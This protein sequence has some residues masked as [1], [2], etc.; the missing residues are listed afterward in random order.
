MIIPIV[1][2]VAFYTLAERKI[3]A[4]IQRRTGPN[5]VG[6]WGILQPFADA[7]K[8]IIKEQVKPLRAGFYLFLFAPILTFFISLLALNFLCFKFSRSFFDEYLNFLFF[9]SISS[10]NVFGIIF[11]G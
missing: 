9:L 1:I 4:A 7:L 6:V 5:I 10:F 11:A 2:T 3:I 8:A